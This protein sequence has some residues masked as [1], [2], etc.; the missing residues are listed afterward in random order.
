[1]KI[2]KVLERPTLPCEVNTIFVLSSEHE[3][4]A[5]LSNNDGSELRRIFQERQDLG[6][7]GNFSLNLN[8]VSI[9]TITDYDLEIDYNISVLHGNIVVNKDTL[10]YTA[11]AQLPTNSQDVITI[12]NK[13]YTINLT[14]IVIQAALGWGSV[15]DN[16]N[17][18]FLENNSSAVIGFNII[19]AAYFKLLNVTP[20]SDYNI[21]IVSDPSLSVSVN[22]DQQT[23]IGTITNLPDITYYDLTGVLD[24]YLKKISTNEILGRLRMVVTD[25][26]YNDM[27][28]SDI[29]VAFSQYSLFSN[30][31]TGTLDS[32][33]SLDYVIYRN[34]SLGYNYEIDGNPN[35]I[36]TDYNTTNT[37]LNDIRANGFP[38]VYYNSDNTQ[39][40]LSSSDQ[41]QIRNINIEP[42]FL[43]GGIYRTK[44][45]TVIGFELVDNRTTEIKNNSTLIGDHV[46]EA[47]FNRSDVDVRF[48]FNEAINFGYVF[49]DCSGYNYRSDLEKLAA[50][51]LKV[52]YEY[53]GVKYVS[54]ELVIYLYLSLNNTPVVELGTDTTRLLTISLTPDNKI[55]S[56]G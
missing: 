12:N 37:I 41:D 49:I 56:M 43:D 14:E 51:R 8:D 42:M 22:Y 31:Y 25:G 30:Y 39:Y 26:A 38:S 17:S 48:T 33:I 44:G 35:S 21:E 36:F 20:S 2:N 29:F 46:F 52:Y 55:R 27:Y 15:L 9:Y 1:M 28:T 24:I 54:D 47:N 3:K 11:P 34:D 13:Q 10:T 23:G 5:L 16:V 32:N 7:V 45:K 40:F 50:L 19:T 53:N 4:K 6:L 18:E